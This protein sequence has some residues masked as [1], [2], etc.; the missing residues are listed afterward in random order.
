MS[1][2][3]K[4]FGGKKGDKPPTTGEGIQKLRETEKM[5]MKNQDFIEKKIEQETAIARKKWHRK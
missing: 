4:V 3:A 5:L 2:L 1:F